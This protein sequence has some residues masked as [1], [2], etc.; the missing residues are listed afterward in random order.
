VYAVT[1]DPT[2]PLAR[3]AAEAFLVPAATKYRRAGETPTIQPLSSLFD[4]VTH[5]LLD[6]VCLQL[7]GRRD[8]DNSAAHAAHGNTE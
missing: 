4:Q 1:T 3:V 6:V 8:I 5:I 7:A 2:S